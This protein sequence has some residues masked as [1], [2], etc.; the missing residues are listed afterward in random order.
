[1]SSTS[2]TARNARLGRT[3]LMLAIKHHNLPRAT[4]LILSGADVN[5]VDLS[6]WSALHYAIAMFAVSDTATQQQQRSGRRIVALLVEYG[7]DLEARTSCGLN[8]AML[9]ATNPG[10]LPLL[11][12]LVCRGASVDGVDNEGEGVGAF[13]SGEHAHIVCWLAGLDV[14]DPRREAVC[15]RFESGEHVRFCEFLVALM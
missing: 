8:A 7:A 12:Y 1:M 4:Q 3:P 9:A 6:S 2:A 13:V 10:Y 11:A 15:G 5:R 14:A